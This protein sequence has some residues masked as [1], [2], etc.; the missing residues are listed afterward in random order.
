MSTERSDEVMNKP[1][2]IE[3]TQLNINVLFNHNILYNALSK[4]TSTNR[5]LSWNVS[6]SRVKVKYNQEPPLSKFKSKS[7]KLSIHSN[8]LR[9][10]PIRKIITNEEEYFC[11]KPIKY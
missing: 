7:E 5:S 6:T 4:L 3:Y 10:E 8:I 9:L 1:T 11:Y 2:H